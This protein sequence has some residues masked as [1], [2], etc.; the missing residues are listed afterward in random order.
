M[1]KIT[2]I[3]PRGATTYI[4]NGLV[5]ITKAIAKKHPE[6][7]A[8]GLL[9]GEYGYGACYQNWTFSMHPFCW[10]EKDSCPFCNDG[11]M[12]NFYY[13]DIKKDLHIKWYKYIGRDM[14]MNWKPNRERWEKIV[15]ECIK[16]IL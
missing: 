7:V 5:K 16:S 6:L 11:A 13:G 4:D 15:K 3:I 8:Q 9:G 1:K 14:E 2:V 12:P 10:C